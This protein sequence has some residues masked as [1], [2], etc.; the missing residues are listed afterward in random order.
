MKRVYEYCFYRCA[1]FYKKYEGGNYVFNGLLFYSLGLISNYCT[2]QTLV[3]YFWGIEYNG[4]VFW[5]IPAI[6]GCLIT[7][8]L[9]DKYEK[10]KTFD[11]LEKRYKNSPHWVLRG[12]LVFLRVILSFIL[13]GISLYIFYK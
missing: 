11:K 7:W 10:D 9:S 8:V 1:A 5:T 13:Y 12:W 3:F 6:V 4:R 2:I